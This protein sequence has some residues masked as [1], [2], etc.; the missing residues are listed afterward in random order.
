MKR[1]VFSMMIV[2]VLAGVTQEAAFAETGRAYLR[3]DLEGLFT[4]R[5]RGFLG[6][7]GAAS[8]AMPN[9][10]VL[11][12]FGDTIVGNLR[13]GKKEGPMVRNSIAIVDQNQDVE[14]YWDLTDGI[15][16]DFFHPD[17]WDEPHW[18]WPGAGVAIDGELY[19]LLSKMAKGDGPEGF[20]FQTIGCTLFRVSNPDANPRAWKM[21]KT[22][23]GLASDHFNVNAA[24]FHQDDMVYLLGYHDGAESRSMER[25]AI[26]GRI[27]VSDLGSDSPG[28]AIEYFAGGRSWSNSPG[29]AATL[30]LPG[31][32]ETAIHYD[33]TT[34]KYYSLT[35]QPFQADILLTESASLEGPWSTPR[36]IFQIREVVENDLVHAY[37]PRIHSVLSEPGTITFTYVTN[38]KDFWSVF[39]MMDV[40]YPRFVTY[41]LQGA[42][43]END[44]DR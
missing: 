19:L 7:D 26:L 24:M 27:T 29:E 11:W 41:P 10:N 44:N 23:L 17:N 43:A 18:Y 15:M 3:E 13:N 9:G 34:E 31:T 6:A 5:K 39:S 4:P 21:K 35:I 20:A 8:V 38:T 16:G 30:F 12:I 42:A 36:P 37:T 2:G 32:T 25:R 1:A 40:Y 28:S 14:F 22:E 33:P